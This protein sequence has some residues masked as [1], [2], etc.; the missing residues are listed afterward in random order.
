ME[1]T[2]FAMRHLLELIGHQSSISL[3]RV[4]SV[5]GAA[6]NAL[7]RQI[8]ADV[9]DMQI[10]TLKVREATAL[11]AAMTAG[12]GAG[13]Y[14]DYDEAIECTLPAVDEVVSPDASRHRAYEKP[15][16]VY[17]TLYPALADSMYFAATGKE[18]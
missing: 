17:R 5:G 16:R 3:N 18:P 4:V 13:V 10:V 15:Y 14:D 2:A 11:G 6:R 9:W 1:G 8:K 12:V 7:W